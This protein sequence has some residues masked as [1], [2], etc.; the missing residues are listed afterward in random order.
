VRVV[1]D[2]EEDHVARPQI[3]PVVG[4]LLAGRSGNR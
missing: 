3:V 4:Q 1:L 2:D